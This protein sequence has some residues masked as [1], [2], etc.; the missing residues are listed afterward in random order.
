[1]INR[2][3]NGIKTLAMSSAIKPDVVFVLGAP[4]AGKG[5]QC[6]NIVKVSSDVTVYCLL[7]CCL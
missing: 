1:M 7:S 3:F 4:G 6:E 2:L 5:T